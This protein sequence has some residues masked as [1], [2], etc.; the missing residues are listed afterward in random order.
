MHAQHLF[1]ALPTMSWS[2]YNTMSHAGFEE[3]E[4][5]CRAERGSSNAAVQV[6]PTWTKALAWFSLES[7]G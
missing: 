2:R 1:G 5:A 6:Q 4:L 7:R 3:K